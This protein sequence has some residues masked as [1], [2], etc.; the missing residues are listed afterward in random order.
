MKAAILTIG[1]EILIGQIID[2][3]SAYISRLLNEL[4]VKV[5]VMMSISD[6]RQ[7]IMESLDLLFSKVDIVMITGGLGPTKDDITKH[8]LAEYFGSEKMVLDKATLQ[9][10]KDML[11]RLGVDMIDLN[12]N[13]AWLPDNCEVLYNALGTAPGMWFAKENRLVVSMPGVPYEMEYVM[14]NQVIPRLKERFSLPNIIHKT[15]LTF[16][17]PESRLANQI[18]EWEDALPKHL[19]LAYLPTLSGVKLRISNYD[20]ESKG[21]AEN[22]V[23]QQLVKLRAILK[24]GIVGEGDYTMVDIVSKL[25]VKRG[26]TVATAESCTGGKIAS[27]LTEKSGS[28]AYFKGSIVSYANEVKENIL[29]VNP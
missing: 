1:D 17:I 16:G 12:T 18:S 10:V 9:H 8:V 3:N 22:E 20:V 26:E 4:G 19:H 21:L 29:N 27:M 11:E 14:L 15:I 28:S 24:D 25:L 23:E 13:Q 2:T 5:D 6:R 7:A